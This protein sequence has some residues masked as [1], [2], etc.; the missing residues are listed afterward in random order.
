MRTHSQISQFIQEIKR[1]D[2]FKDLTVVPLIGRKGLCVHPKYKD[3]EKVESLN[4]KCQDLC[5]SKNGCPYT[6]V[7]AMGLVEDN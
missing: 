1:V 6:Q 3:M 7:D 5:E 4:D 2:K